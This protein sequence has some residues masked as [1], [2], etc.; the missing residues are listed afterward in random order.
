M[1]ARHDVLGEPLRRQ[2]VQADVYMALTDYGVMPAPYCRC[3][4]G[5]CSDVRSWL[6]RCDRCGLLMMASTVG[7]LIHL[8][9][10]GGA[11]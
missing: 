9:I 11:L 2:A 4:P 10:V 1:S 7:E 5:V 6:I 8:R 3:A